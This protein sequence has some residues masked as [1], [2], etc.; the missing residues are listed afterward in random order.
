[1]PVPL[2]YFHLVA[3]RATLLDDDGIRLA[4]RKQALAYARVLMTELARSQQTQD[5]IIVVENDDDGEL[6]EVAPSGPSL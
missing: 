1:L 3:A 4:D 5:G 2:F 6:F